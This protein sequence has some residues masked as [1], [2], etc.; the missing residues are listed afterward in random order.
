MHSRSIRGDPALLPYLRSGA[1][2]TQAE[3]LMKKASTCWDA[4]GLPDRTR[5]PLAS[6]PGGFYTPL[7]P[8]ETAINPALNSLLEPLISPSDRWLLEIP[9]VLVPGTPSAR[10]IISSSG[11]AAMGLPWA[12]FGG[13]FFYNELVLILGLESHQAQDV[14]INKPSALRMKSYDLLQGRIR[15]RLLNVAA[16]WFTGDNLDAETH[17]EIELLGTVLDHW[18][19]YQGSKYRD[20]IWSVT[21][22][23]QAMMLL[24]ELGHVQAHNQERST[25]RTTYVQEQDPLDFQEIFSDTWGLPQL[26]KLSNI[27]FNSEPTLVIW[28]VRYIFQILSH[29][30]AEEIRANLA[31]RCANLIALLLPEEFGHLQPDNCLA[32]WGEDAGLLQSPGLLAPLYEDFASYLIMTFENPTDMQDV[33]R[34]S[35]PYYAARLDEHVQIRQGY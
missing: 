29:F 17:A 23:Q 2:S 25:P 22:F 35:H 10:L 3:A 11:G 15:D 34:E 7:A 5:S 13:L 9:R 21:V 18:R 14:T 32:A 27:L 4:Y 30:S 33:V 12:A 26:R 28:P 1:E 20:H 6:L 19:R 8:D 16:S 31:V 24:H